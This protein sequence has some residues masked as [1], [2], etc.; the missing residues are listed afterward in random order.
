MAAVHHVKAKSDQNDLKNKTKLRPVQQYIG[1]SKHG[2]WPA[3]ELEE[4]LDSS[5]Q[6]LVFGSMR[7]SGETIECS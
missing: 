7:A 6:V 2:A 4:D 5:R 3:G 1:I